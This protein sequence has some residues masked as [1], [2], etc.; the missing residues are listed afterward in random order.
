MEDQ[1][2][3]CATSKEYLQEKQIEE[4]NKKVGELSLDNE[5]LK[6]DIAQMKANERDM[7]Q[8]LRNLSDKIDKVDEDFMR[9]FK[10]TQT[11]MSY[12]QEWQAREQEKTDKKFNFVLDELQKRNGEGNKVSSMGTLFSDD[13]DYHTDHVDNEQHG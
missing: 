4:L 8:S 9:Q 2:G 13:S 1:Q 5:E 3:K 7:L 12:R 6:K 11:Y 10:C